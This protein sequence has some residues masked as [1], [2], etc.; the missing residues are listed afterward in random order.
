MT[1]SGMEGVAL[2]APVG[3]TPLKQRIVAALTAS[4]ARRMGY[5]DLARTLWPPDQCPRAWRYSANG[6]PPGWAMPLGR[7]LRELRE[8]GVAYEGRPRGGG[9][10]HGVVVLLTP[11]AGVTGLLPAQTVEI[12][13]KPAGGRSELT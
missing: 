9:A 11:N 12:P 5:H 13:P 1:R 6:G 4:P 8:A 2:E 3:L 10:G 7:A